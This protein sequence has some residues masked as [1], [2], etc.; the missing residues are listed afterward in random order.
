MPETGYAVVPIPNSLDVDDDLI[1]CCRPVA[2]SA[3]TRVG[4]VLTDAPPVTV[5]VYGADGEP[6]DVPGCDFALR[7]EM[8]R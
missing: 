5:R 2:E 3:A 4:A 8:V 1:A 7:F 6:L